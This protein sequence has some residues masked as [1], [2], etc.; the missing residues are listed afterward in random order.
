MAKRR[1]GR[2]LKRFLQLVAIFMLSSFLV[3][4]LSFEAMRTEDALCRET[5]TVT[6]MPT[7]LLAKGYVFRQE[8]VT[9]SAY[10]GPIIY[11]AADGA[12]VSE[13][14][15]LATVYVG[16]GGT[17]LREAAAALLTE[18]AR[19]QALGASNVI[20]DYDGSYAS[21]MSALSS[22]SMRDTEQAKATL[23]AA[24]ALY[25]AKGEDASVRAARIAA[26]QAEL[27]S[28][29]PENTASETV[30]APDNGV[31]YTDTDGYEAVFTFS[32]LESLTPDGLR[33]LLASQQNT[34]TAIGKIV[35]TKVWYLALPCTAADVAAFS[36]GNTYAA[37]FSRTDE[38]V[39]LTLD[40]IT[41]VDGEGELLLIFRAT[42]HTPPADMARCAEVEIV[43]GSVTG[44][45]IPQIALRE[46][47]GAC[48]VL[49]DQEG[50]ATYRRIEPLLMRDGY[51][52]AALVADAAYLQI[53]EEI[54]VTHRRIYSG[55]VLK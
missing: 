5:A 12:A 6:T 39:M 11:G 49:V 20:P 10:S 42:G 36:V 31:F 13:G 53:G 18:I 24:L 9:T 44:L 46:Q 33:T 14:D 35:Q 28:M 54:L 2:G 23:Q 52:L 21:L 30:K 15:T 4:I 7:T 3:A 37:H 17:A 41:D 16:T 25:A 34:S 22:G 45:W 40:R 47:D 50:V 26:L 43:T 1:K 38:A 29:I 48:G 51:C 27:D 32:A 55:K 8:A 19:L